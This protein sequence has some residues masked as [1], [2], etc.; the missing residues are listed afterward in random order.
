MSEFDN[1]IAL[2]DEQIANMTGAVPFTGAPAPSYGSRDHRSR[3]R[4]VAA[5]RPA[6]RPRALLPGAGMGAASFAGGA[7]ELMALR[8]QLVQAKI[9]SE[10][11][12]S[13]ASL[14]EELHNLQIQEAR[15]K[16]GLTFSG[17]RAQMG[18]YDAMY[19]ASNDPTALRRVPVPF[20]EAGVAAGTQASIV[21]EPQYDWKGYSLRISPTVAAAF[22]INDIEVGTQS[23]FP[24]RADF[25]SD[26]L[27]P[28]DVMGYIETWWVPSRTEVRLTVTN[29][30]G[31]DA[32]F[33]ALYWGFARA[34]QS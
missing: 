31:A 32:D 1:A 23:I 27:D 12:M 6:P 9:Q 18:V 21:Q 5:S 14:Q 13:A 26:L 16:A 20:F 4:S 7:S 22:E 3:P 11:A 29:T 2:L 30:S 24:A 33:S 25:L 17:N 15:A 8:N 34:Q 10:Q 28:L 19:A